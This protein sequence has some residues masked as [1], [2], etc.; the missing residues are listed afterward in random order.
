[1]VPLMVR[2][3]R[4]EKVERA[5]AWMMRQAGR[6][7]KEY[8]DLAVKH[9]SFRERSE[10]TDLIVDITLQPFRA[11]KPDGVIL[12]SDILTPFPAF[13][14]DFEIDDYKGP[15]LEKT[16]RTKEDLKM[17]HDVDLSK[18]E[19]V[20]ESLKILRQ[21][22]GNDAAVL[23][24]VG[25]PWTLCT[26][27]V[28]GQSTSTYKTIKSMCFNNPDVLHSLLSSVA[29][30]LAVYVGFQIDAGAQVIQ[31]FDSW[32][33]QLPPHMWEEWSKPYIDRVVRKVQQ[34]HPGTPITLYANG[35]GGLLERMSTLTVDTIG[36]DWTIDMEDGRRRV[37]DKAVQGNVDP[38]VLFAGEDAIE[39]AVKDVCR[40]AGPTGH[41]L[42]LGHG[43]LVGTPEESVKHFFDVSKTI[44]Y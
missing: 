28:E 14:I 10:T 5:P 22:V 35:S 1:M 16:I 34:T 4:K 41:V 30:A 44:T 31:V 37:G 11:F 32:G 13:G 9:P 21:E 12:F 27:I 23:G 33:G 3:A 2:A 40:K 19:F 29:D 15:M 25:A 36:L 7:M 18:V 43:V 39:K 8:R 20:A 26:Y 24:F 17:L 42:N 6:Y 38:V